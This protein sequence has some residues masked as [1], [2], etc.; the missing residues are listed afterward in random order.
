MGRESAKLAKAAAA[1][2]QAA[3]NARTDLGVVMAD[4]PRVETLAHSVSESFRAI[5]TEAAGQAGN[6]EAGLNRLN[7]EHGRAHE[8]AS[9]AT[10]RPTEASANMQRDTE[11]THKPME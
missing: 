1:L 8:M 3:A 9:G 11:R 5:G 2:D 10:N 7:N 4:L 6:L